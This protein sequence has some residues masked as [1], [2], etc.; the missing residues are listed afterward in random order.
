MFAALGGIGQTTRLGNYSVTFLEERDALNDKLSKDLRLRQKETTSIY[1]TREERIDSFL[2][3]RD[4]IG[5]RRT[6]AREE[7]NILFVSAPLEGWS[8]GDIE[9]KLMHSSDRKDNSGTR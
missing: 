5:Y 8:R 9:K 7:D 3:Q 6:H 4:P 1:G 2:K